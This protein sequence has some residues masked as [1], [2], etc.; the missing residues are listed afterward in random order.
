MD[1]DRAFS[2]AQH[3]LTVSCCCTPVTALAP[4]VGACDFSCPS[5]ATPTP[6]LF[7]AGTPAGELVLQCHH[8]LAELKSLSGEPPSPHG[9]LLHNC[10]PPQCLYATSQPSSATSGQATNA[11]PLTSTCGH[12]AAVPCTAFNIN[13]LNRA[14]HR[15]QSISPH[16][17][18]ILAIFTM[19]FGLLELDPLVLQHLDSRN[20][21]NSLERIHISPP[22]NQE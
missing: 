5:T 18:R 1:V 16:T 11:F 13:G 22:T 3:H 21:T 2:W 6:W 7:I 9:E 4:C 17:Y 10:F 15:H 14:T 19:P 12:A 8:S 20:V